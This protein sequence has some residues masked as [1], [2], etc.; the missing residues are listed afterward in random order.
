MLEY[1]LEELFAK[2][3]N[4]LPFDENVSNKAVAMYYYIA[5]CSTVA[6]YSVTT[7]RN[8]LSHFN[9]KNVDRYYS[10]YIEALIELEDNG[11]ID[12]LNNDFEVIE[13]DE[14]TKDSLLYINLN[15]KEGNY[16]Q[17]YLQD[18]KSC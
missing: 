4:E 1:D 17:A 3:P 18:I 5:E 16:F 12:I 15:R 8:L 2:I 13:R 10:I 6:N 7:V 14:I 9:Y 11:Y